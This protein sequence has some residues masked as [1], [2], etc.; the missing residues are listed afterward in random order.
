MLQTE[1]HGDIQ[2]RIRRPS[3][4]L[5]AADAVSVLNQFWNNGLV[6]IVRD[7]Q[8]SLTQMHQYVP[9]VLKNDT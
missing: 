1:L 2:N 3:F 6:K 5:D 8:V 7:R 9:R 4:Y